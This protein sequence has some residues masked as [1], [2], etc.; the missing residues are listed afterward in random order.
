MK[1][2]HESSNAIHTGQA[3]ELFCVDNS[4]FGTQ[5]VA[6]N[7]SKAHAEVQEVAAVHVHVHRTTV[8]EPVRI[9]LRATFIVYKVAIS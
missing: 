4:R 5:F 7:P 6:H 3:V 1:M 8:L 9:K 2:W